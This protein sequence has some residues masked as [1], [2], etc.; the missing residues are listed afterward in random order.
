MKRG[1]KK[2]APFLKAKKITTTL[3]RDLYMF[4]NSLPK[5]AELIQRLMRE[6]E[7]FKD[8]ENNLF[9]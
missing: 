9:S 4:Y 5:K 2:K 1:R 8:Y 6:S 3:P 7:E